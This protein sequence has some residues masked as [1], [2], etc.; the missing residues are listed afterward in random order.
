MNKFKVFSMPVAALLLTFGLFT[1]TKAETLYGMTHTG[2]AGNLPGVTLVRFDSATPGTLTTIGT[3]STGL[4]AGHGVRSIDFRP[5]NGLLYAI[6]TDA[7]GA[8]GQLYSVSLTN[9]QLFPIGAGFSLGT[10]TD[11]NVSMDF[12][13]VVD[14]IR[15]VTGS[16]GSNGT[17]TNFRVNPNDGT[18]VATDTNIAYDAADPNFGADTQIIAIAYSNNTVGAANTTLYAWEWQLDS[19]TRIGS[20]T[21]TPVSPNA[22]TLFTVADPGAFI[23]NSSGLGM[24][25]SG[26]TGTCYVAHNLDGQVTNVRLRTRNL[27]TG[28]ETDIGAFPAGSNVHDISVQP[29]VTASGVTLSGRVA[30]GPQGR[31]IIN[32]VVSITDSNGVVRTTITGKGGQYSFEDL[33]T[34]GSYVVTVRSRNYNFSPRVVQLFDNLSDIDFFA[35][36]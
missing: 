35:G 28:A 6:S 36:Q 32:V 11:P 29:A 21:G 10:N 2:A 16:L 17:N 23:T 9:A 5:L 34:G 13:P 18:L 22:G 27:T 33:E 20:L 15:V 3:F 7:T 12:N 31:G 26:A 19:L 25:I 4:V 14:R 1:V 8:N 30:L 24:D